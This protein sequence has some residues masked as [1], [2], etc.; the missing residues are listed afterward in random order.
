MTVS[1]EQKLAVQTI[2]ER[3]R[4]GCDNFFTD[5]QAAADLIVKY[6]E[7]GKPPHPFER[8]IKEGVY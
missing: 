4:Y 1:N 5:S 7:D 6:L 3:S 8:D 2:I